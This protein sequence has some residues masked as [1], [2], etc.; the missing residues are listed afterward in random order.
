MSASTFESNLKCGFGNLNTF[1]KNTS[2][3][4]EI[5]MMI[6]QLHLREGRLAHFITGVTLWM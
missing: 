4:N 5:E 2:D 6:E 3:P 1:K